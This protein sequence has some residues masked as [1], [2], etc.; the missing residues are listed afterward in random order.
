MPENPEA[1]IKRLR[2][3]HWAVKHIETHGQHPVAK[4]V[5]FPRCF[6]EGT[7][8]R[9][10]KS[11]Q[12]TNH[13][14]T[15][16]TEPTT[17][18]F[19][20]NPHDLRS[21]KRDGCTHLVDRHLQPGPL[22]VTT[23][24]KCMVVAAGHHAVTV[25]FGLEATVYILTLA[26]FNAILEGDAPGPNKDKGKASRL[27]V[28]NLPDK[29]V[30]EGSV[31]AGEKQRTIT[32]LAAFVAE[33]H[34]IV[35]TD[36]ARLMRLH[37]S[38]R[39]TMW[40]AEDLDVGSYWW[41]EVLWVMFPDGPD[42]YYE[43]REALEALHAWRQRMLDEDAGFNQ[44]IVK[45]LTLNTS[46]AFGGIGR[47][48]ANDP[49]FRA[50]IHP[51]LS[52]FYVCEHKE[53]WLW[54]KATI[55]SYM[56]TWL[57]S[58][59]IRDCGSDVNSLNPF[60]FNFTSNTNYLKTYTLVYYKKEVWVDKDLCNRYLKLG[61]LDESHV[62][63]E[64]YELDGADLCEL[65]KRRIK[66]HLLDVGSNTE[67]FTIITA[68]L[69]DDTGGGFRVQK[70]WK[71]V[72]AQGKTTAVGPASFREVV[73]NKIDY[74]AAS[75]GST[76]LIRRGRPSKNKTKRPGRPSMSLTKSK[77]ESR[78]SKVPKRLAAGLKENMALAVVEDTEPG[79][80]ESS[81]DDKS[82]P[83]MQLPLIPS[84]RR[85]RSKAAS[86]SKDR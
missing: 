36:F 57:S 12:F 66:V 2:I 55:T 21:A 50:A 82:S 61:Y 42:W 79:R 68:M 10:Y 58:A 33:T 47:H 27:R 8:K 80:E 39:D 83:A 64:P 41:K 34:A 7:D 30:E 70:E 46:M 37:V 6:C 43:R 9:Q 67:A 38:S 51:G 72:Q 31:K 14:Y 32:T 60:A 28:F 75:S 11:L 23:R 62:I 81:S 52:S 22:H 69:P 17:P 84:P 4:L 77:I 63:D 3:A 19:I 20:P 53:T 59:F 73:Q 49:L 48:L 16:W 65:S 54:L 24:G 5:V 86:G 76:T 1:I 71:D 85:T 13:G 40:A 78:A 35:F 29:F 56:D 44:P 15:N 45:A 18:G 25:N 74:S 26:D